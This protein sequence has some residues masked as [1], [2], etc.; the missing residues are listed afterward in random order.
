MFTDVEERSTAMEARAFGSTA[1]RT[2]LIPVPDSMVQR[3]ARWLFVVLAL[4]A[5]ATPIALGL[6]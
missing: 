2:S 3:I 1:K 6:L 4:A 5:V